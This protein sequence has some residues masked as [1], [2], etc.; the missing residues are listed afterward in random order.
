MRGF[1]WC[2][3]AATPTPKVNGMTTYSVDI[4]V[5][6]AAL[7]R[8]G[9]GAVQ[10]NDDTQESELFRSAYRGIV[11]DALNQSHSWT[12][13]NRV[14]KLVFLGE[15]DS[16]PK[17]KYQKPSDML[18]ARTMQINGRAY[19]DYQIRENAI[20]TDVRSEDIYFEYTRAAPPS[21]WPADFAEGVV[22][23]IISAIHQ[24]LYLDTEEARIWMQSGNQ[25]IADARAR[26]RHKQRDAK[27]T[28]NP[29]LVNAWRGGRR[30]R[31]GRSRA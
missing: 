10:E 20:F 27:R 4:Q 31:L 19:Q 9:E 5:F 14:A 23:L 11:N 24:G 15:V 3:V 17:Y 18:V 26:D 29:V 25:K 12:F 6:N 2:V 21:D 30:Q 16:Y 1:F 7:T 8:C 28:P 13:A 22:H